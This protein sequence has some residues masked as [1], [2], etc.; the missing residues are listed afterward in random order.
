MCFGTHH[1]SEATDIRLSAISVIL[2]LSP[3]PEEMDK[4]LGRLW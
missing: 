2:K 1:C 4:L 3:S